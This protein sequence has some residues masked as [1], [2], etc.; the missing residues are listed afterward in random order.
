M[1][2]ELSAD[3]RIVRVPLL[4]DA[5]LDELREQLVDGTLPPATHIVIKDVASGMGVSTVP[6]REA[7]KVLQSEGRVIHAPGRGYTVRQLSY[8]EMVQVNRLAMMVESE[9][10]DTGVPNLTANE[11]AEMAEMLAIVADPDSTR[12]ER[13]EAHRAFHLIPMR[14]A[15]I[16]IFFE[17]VERLWDHYEHYRLLFFDSNALEESARREHQEFLEACQKRDVTAALEVH[18]RHRNSSFS[19]LTELANESERGEPHHV[20]DGS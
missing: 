3:P 16:G 13:L 18:R 14:A 12:I 10:L 20:S 7:L 11:A 1:G 9:T 2:P 4:Q 6:V 8:E 17:V 19:Q 5:V 15:R